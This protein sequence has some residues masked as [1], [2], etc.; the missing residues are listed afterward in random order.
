MKRWQIAWL[1]VVMLWG[2]I[3]FATL[4]YQILAAPASLA[5]PLP[6][7]AVRLFQVVTLPAAGLYVLMATL[8]RLARWS[9]GVQY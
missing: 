7:L 1:I 6:P 9:P 2:N 8:A 3:V 5:G 4:V